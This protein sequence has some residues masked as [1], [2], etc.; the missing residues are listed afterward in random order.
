MSAK[1][2]FRQIEKTVY[3]FLKPHG[4]RK[5]GA[6]Y[7]ASNGDLTYVLNL[8]KSR[9]STQDFLKITVNVGIM[10][11][12]LSVLLG[13]AHRAVDVSLCHWRRRIG[14]FLDQ[15]DDKWWFVE[16][17]DQADRAAKEVIGLI[18]S[19]VFVAFRGLMSTAQ[20]VELWAQG[21]SPGIT[22]FSRQRYLDELKS[23]AE[24]K[25]TKE[26]T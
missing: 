10:S 7:S 12:R 5:K 18:G 4:Y 8:Q 26:D 15:P 9:D 1:D 25:K 3:S 14:G 24:D 17:F 21:E 13:H 2:W 16:D 20:L 11:G 6:T 22:D 23:D 19:R